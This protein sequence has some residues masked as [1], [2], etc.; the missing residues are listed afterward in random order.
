MGGWFNSLDVEYL[1]ESGKWVSAKNV[2]ITPNL[3]SPELLFIRPNFV[4]YVLSFDN[5][6]SKAIRII[7]EVGGIEHWFNKKIYHF[8]SIT[9]LSVYESIPG[10]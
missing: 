1:D 9:E 3:P 5:V 7:G 10:L 2:K 4:E 8:T 6:K